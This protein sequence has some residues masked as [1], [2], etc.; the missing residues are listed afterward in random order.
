[1]VKSREPVVTA[2]VG[3][4][5]MCQGEEGSLGHWGSW[6]TPWVPGRSQGSLGAAALEIREDSSSQ[7]CV[8]AAGAVRDPV[9]LCG[10][11]LQDGTH[12]SLT[13]H[14]AQSSISCIQMDG[15]VTI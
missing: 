12:S 4:S 11:S 8:L 9:A 13:E 7:G 15:S 2:G 10:D 1:M 14:Q 5:A 6:G 3:G